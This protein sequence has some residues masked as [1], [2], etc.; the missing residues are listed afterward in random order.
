MWL[1]MC[2]M[3]VP[4]GGHWLDQTGSHAKFSVPTD[5]QAQKASR[6]MLAWLIVARAHTW[7]NDSI[8]CPLAATADTQGTC[9]QTHTCRQQSTVA[10]THDRRNHCITHTHSNAAGGNRT[11]WAHLHIVEGP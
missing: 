9:I 5:K 6:P 7:Q 10:G 2:D 11:N 3:H 8:T 4:A 1:H